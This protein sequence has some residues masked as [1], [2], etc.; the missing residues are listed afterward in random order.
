MGAGHDRQGVSRVDD[1][2]DRP[3]RAGDG[4]HLA[5]PN[6]LAFRPAAEGKGII[7]FCGG[8]RTQQDRRRR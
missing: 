1:A 5:S 3:A 2:T 7:L 6:W 8:G 4:L